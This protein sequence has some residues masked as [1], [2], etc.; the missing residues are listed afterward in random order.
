[1]PPLVYI[2]LL[3]LP[4]FGIAAIIFSPA[5]RIPYHAR[6]S[7]QFSFRLTDCLALLVPIQFVFGVIT[8]VIPKELVETDTA[9]GGGIGVSL[10][11]AI[12]WYFG[13]RILQ[14]AGVA[15]WLR[16]A[17]FL[18]VVIPL[19]VAVSVLAIPEMCF[20]K[21]FP[22]ALSVPVFLIAIVGLRLVN[23]WIFRAD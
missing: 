19:G 1:M 23:Q 15:N 18:S 5:F 8:F 6:E 20:A 14:R 13:A 12:M 2:L 11:I 3:G 17:I 4:T 10:G 22:L 16:R 7:S 9:I 21:Q